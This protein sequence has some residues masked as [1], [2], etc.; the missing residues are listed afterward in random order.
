MGTVASELMARS[1]VVPRSTLR[2]IHRLAAAVS[3]ASVAAL[4]VMFTLYLIL[5]WWE[6]ITADLALAAA[7]TSGLLVGAFAWWRQ[8]L[9][10][11]DAVGV[12]WRGLF[13]ARTIPWVEIRD[14][15]IDRGER[16][17]FRAR[18]R[19]VDLLL[20]DGST[21]RVGFSSFDPAGT[22]AKIRALEGAKPWDQ[23]AA[24]FRSYD[25]AARLANADLL[26]EAAPRWEG[27]IGVFSSMHDLRFVPRGET[28]DAVR[29]VRV[30]FL[31]GDGGPAFSREEGVFTF[32]L[33]MPSANDARL[34]VLRT[35]DKAFEPTAAVVLDAFLM[36]LTGRSEAIPG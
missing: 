14:V 26:E 29:S 32:E 13:R 10:V 20:L 30:S 15:T 9:V 35:A 22:A 19:G 16:S 12:A 17:P 8:D 27:H 24:R 36:Q 28:F 6:A 5:S 4:A 25:V 31:A 23:L 33:W 34:A 3:I 18:T 7:L 21:V 1:T 11:D 2:P